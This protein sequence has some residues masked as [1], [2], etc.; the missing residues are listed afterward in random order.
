MLCLK[1]SFKRPLSQNK[2]IA[3]G[4]LLT[5]FIKCG[6]IYI[7]NERQIAEIWTSFPHPQSNLKIIER[8]IQLQDLEKFYFSE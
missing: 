5:G 4:I 8:H 7:E 1:E 2:F 3:R 6:S